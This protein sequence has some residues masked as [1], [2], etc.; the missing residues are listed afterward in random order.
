MPTFELIE[1]LEFFRW[2]NHSIF[3]LPATI[4][5]ASAAVILTLKTRFIQIRA[6]PRFIHMIIH[7]IKHE[8]G[9][10][11]KT[12]NPFH[13]LFTAMATT[14][15]M[16]NIV[17]PPI[18]IIAGGPGAL[19]W[20]IIYIFFGSVTK[21]TEVSFALDTRIETPKGI[22][23]GPIQYLKSISR[24]LAYWYGFVIVFL[25]VSWSSLQSN[26]LANIAARENIPH[27]AVGLFLAVT[28][29]AVLN[30]GAQRVGNV[31]SRLVP[32]M[33]VLYVSFALLILLKDPL[34][35][36]SAVRLVVRSV[37]HPSAAIGG[38][39]GATMLRAMNSG[40]SRAVFVTEAGLG[41]SSIAHAT[42]D[43]EKPL[44][45]GILAMG[46]MIA[47]LFLVCLSGFLILVTGAWMVVGDNVGSTLIY[48]AFKQ[49]APAMGS[50]VLLI[51][52]TLFV[53]TTV[54]G[55]G[56]N[57][58]QSFGALTNYRYTRWYVA[59]TVIVVFLGALSPVPLV[60]E[61][62]DTLLYLVAIPNLLGLLILAFKRPNVLRY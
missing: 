27:W 5:F 38:F 21:L 46:A 33:F 58:V 39:A 3:A 55:N 11:P 23:G 6:F 54:I 49:H 22:I 60:W 32:L 15:G 56:F 17:V 7:G 25:F 35:L 13:A 30:G 2:L 44:D 48:D 53:L 14:I 34:A 12:I 42:A 59:F 28:L 40:F 8:Q 43:T 62:Q 10:H 29:L 24:L 18:A 20:M 51:S 9:S 52:I 16:G 19:F 1:C 61:I 36:W 47:D 26:T 41:T 4:L 31:A 37:L 50:I 45:Q 57:G